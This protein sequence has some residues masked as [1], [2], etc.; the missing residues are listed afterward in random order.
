MSKTNHPIQKR[1]G[2]QVHQWFVF[3]LCATQLIYS[4]H[5]L[6]NVK[7][8]PPDSKA[9]A[10]DA[11]LPTEARACISGTN[12]WLERAHQGSIESTFQ[13]RPDSNHSFSLEVFSEKNRLISNYYRYATIGLFRTTTVTRHRGVTGDHKKCEN[14]AGGTTGGYYTSCGYGS[15]MPFSPALIRRR[16]KKNRKRSS[17]MHGV[18]GW[19]SA[20]FTFQ[21]AKEDMRRDNTAARLLRCGTP[22]PQRWHVNLNIVP[23]IILGIFCFTH[24]DRNH[25]D[26]WRPVASQSLASFS[27]QVKNQYRAF[28]PARRSSA[29][30]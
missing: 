3:Y 14:P 22:Q 2:S 23:C 20:E 25:S 1:A 6:F 4:L 13:V 5:L 18:I 7:N 11:A 17:V 30:Y 24:S 16:R 12:V 19:L 29:L 8:E 27:N 28:K 15:R 26:S 9:R 10:K 21:W